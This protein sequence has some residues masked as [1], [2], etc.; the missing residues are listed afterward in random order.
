M[1]DDILTSLKIQIKDA[2]SNYGI[3]IALIVIGF[4]IGFLFKEYVSDRHYRKQIDLRFK[5][6]DDYIKSLK[7]IVI[8]RL[9]KVEVD[10]KDKSFF[11]KIKKFFT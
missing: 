5:E 11:N 2:I 1:S 10:K 3:T 4:T 8:E 6:K 7:V 9:S